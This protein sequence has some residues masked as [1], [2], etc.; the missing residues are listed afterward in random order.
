MKLDLSATD[1]QEIALCDGRTASRDVTGS[2]GG[3]RADV[4]LL[5]LGIGRDWRGEANSRGG[6]VDGLMAE[7]T[8]GAGVGG[9]VDVVVPDH[10]ERR[11]QNQ[12]KERQGEYET[13]DS[14]SLGHVE[15]RVEAVRLL[16]L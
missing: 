16:H 15:G 6:C 5:G 4:L 14:S 10:A 3:R 1:L 12:R 13:P 11:P 8:D 9:R 7:M 2:R